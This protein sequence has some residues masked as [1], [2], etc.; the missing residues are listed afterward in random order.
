MCLFGKDF[1]LFYYVW[2]GVVNG[3]LCCDCIVKFYKG[4]VFVGGSV[5]VLNDVI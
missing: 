3:V 4:D 5:F 2:V 1:F